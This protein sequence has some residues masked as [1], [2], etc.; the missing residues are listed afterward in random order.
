MIE[1]Q[2]INIEISFYLRC[3]NVASC[4]ATATLETANLD[5]INPANPH[6]A[7]CVPD[8]YAMGVAR[9]R[10][11]LKHEIQTG[12]MSPRDAYTQLHYCSIRLVL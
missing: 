10:D 5:V 3:K 4:F 11:A 7:A 8:P 6:S 12:R 2:Y 9:L 1:I